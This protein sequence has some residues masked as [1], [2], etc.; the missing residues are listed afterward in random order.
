[1][2]KNFSIAM[3]LCFTLLFAACSADVNSKGRQLDENLLD[4]NNHLK[5]SIIG[6]VLYLGDH[7][8]RVYRYAEK[9][10]AD[11]FQSFL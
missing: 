6:P 11:K 10:K 3:L 9:N 8:C 2:K 1:M 4:E 5:Y 7:A